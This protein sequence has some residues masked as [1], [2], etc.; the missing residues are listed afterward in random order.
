MRESKTLTEL[1][2]DL[3]AALAADD[4]PSLATA[5]AELRVQLARHRTAG[6]E[7]HDVERIDELRKRANQ[8]LANRLDAD[9]EA[10]ATTEIMIPDD[11]RT[12]ADELATDDPRFASLAARAR[13]VFAARLVA[14]TAGSEEGD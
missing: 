1:R 11:Y 13:E 3:D 10:A 4:V 12:F 6:D 14:G 8:A 9:V 5:A 7:A 2:S